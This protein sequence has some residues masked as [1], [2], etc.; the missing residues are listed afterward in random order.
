M[1]PSVTE[2]VAACGTTPCPIDCVWEWSGNE[3]QCT[4]TCGD[5][6]VKKKFRTIVVEGQYGGTECPPVVE[7]ITCGL[8]KCVSVRRVFK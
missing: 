7:E 2:Q 8:K 4:A 1:C 5:E 6:E 3:T